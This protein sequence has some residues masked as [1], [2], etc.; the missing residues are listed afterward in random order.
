MMRG[1]ALT[2]SGIIVQ[3]PEGESRFVP[4]SSELLSIVKREKGH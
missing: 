4:V 1:M 3:L 2:P